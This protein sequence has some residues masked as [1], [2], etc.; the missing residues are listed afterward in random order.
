MLFWKQVIS[1]QNQNIF[2]LKLAQQLHTSEKAPIF[3][4]EITWNDL[5]KYSC[6]TDIQIW[7][8]KHTK[9]WYIFVLVL[10]QKQLETYLFV[11]LLS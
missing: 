2:L 8:V 10:F 4:L 11:S 5:H 6:S 3:V 1:I 9:H 7:R